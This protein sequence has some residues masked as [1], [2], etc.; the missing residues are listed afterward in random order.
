MKICKLIFST[1]RLEYL[2][3]TLESTEKYVDWGDHEV[4]GLFIDDMPTDRN[5]EEIS[6]LAAK[7]GYTEIVLHKKNQGISAAWKAS[8]ELIKDKGYDF[9]WYQEDDIIIN[10]HVRIND[11]IKYLDNNDSCYQ[12]HLSRQLDWYCKDQKELHKR[13]GNQLKEWENFKTIPH[14]S[15]TF[16][17]SFSLTKGNHFTKALSMWLNGDMPDT[18][19]N[20]TY[21]FAE[22]Y[23]YEVFTYYSEVIN[24]NDKPWGITFYDKDSNK[25]TEHI[26]EWSWGRR[27][28]LEYL[29]NDNS[30]EWFREQLKQQINNPTQKINSRTWEKL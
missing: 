17:A 11:I 29:E 23:I 22:G 14:I 2:I 6:N 26:G 8:Y 20:G 27:V 9:I 25:I 12:V 10:Q 19:G 13:G 24:N 18:I 28:P 3:P 5:G 15:N 4:D 21:I 16:S 30:G 1:N 7:H